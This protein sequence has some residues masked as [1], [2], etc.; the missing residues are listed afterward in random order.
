MP[1]EKGKSGNPG[2]RKKPTAEEIDL[3]AACRQMG[4]QALEVIARIMNHGQSDMV[5]RR[6]AMAIIERGYGVPTAPKAAEGGISKE[7][8]LKRLAD[9]LPD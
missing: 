2:G 8:L 1:F 3:A 6:A 5:C 7:E 4:P 9:S